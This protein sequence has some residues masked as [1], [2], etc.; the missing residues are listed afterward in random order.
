MASTFWSQA[1]LP[2]PLLSCGFSAW[3]SP[4]PLKSWNLPVDSRS[5]P[6]HTQLLSPLSVQ[7]SPSPLCPLK[8]VCGYFHPASPS[9]ERHVRHSIGTWCGEVSRASISEL[10]ELGSNSSSTLLDCETL[11]KLFKLPKPQSPSLETEDNNH[12]CRAYLTDL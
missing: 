3:A 12:I 1:L 9:P 7:A 11:G 4:T 5:C 6:P 2:L 8:S 10:E